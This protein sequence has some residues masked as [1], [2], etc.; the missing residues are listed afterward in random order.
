MSI[1]SKKQIRN[2]APE[3]QELVGSLLAQRMRERQ[4]LL[5]QARRYN[6]M[7]W[8]SACL[9]AAAIGLAVYAAG[10]DQIRLLSLCVIALVM[11]VQFHAIGLN[12]RLDA[13]MKLM[14]TDLKKGPEM[15]NPD[16][17]AP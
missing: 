8:G 9:G 6:G 12:R 7:R 17:A 3:Q 2:M 13:L 4:R 15:V 14:E 5:E 1:L 10:K 16:D 11:F